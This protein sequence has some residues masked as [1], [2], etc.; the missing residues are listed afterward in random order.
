ML[1]C[2]IMSLWRNRPPCLPQCG[3]QTGAGWLV[4]VWM[5]SADCVCTIP[6][7]S[8][9]NFRIIALICGRS[10]CLEKYKRGCVVSRLVQRFFR[11]RKFAALPGQQLQMPCQKHSRRTSCAFRLRPSQ[12]PRLWHCCVARLPVCPTGIACGDARCAAGPGTALT[13]DGLAKVSGL[14]FA[15]AGV[16]NPV[17]YRLIPEGV[18][19]GRRQATI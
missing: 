12:N 11:L 3:W 1:A 19:S 6:D 14:F 7:L 17:N 18:I 2:A 10:N 15:S 16:N 9:C 8:R 13:S 5:Q 4:E